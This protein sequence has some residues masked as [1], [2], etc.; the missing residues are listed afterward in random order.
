MFYGIDKQQQQTMQAAIESINSVYQQ[1][2]HADH[3]ITVGRNMGFLRDPHF[4][5]AMENHATNEQESS[6]A[7]RLHTLMWAAEHCLHL[8]GEFVECGVY[9]GFSTAVLAEYLDFSKVEKTFFLYDTFDGMPKESSRLIG[10]GYREYA[11]PGLYEFVQKRFAGYPN[12]QLVRG[13]IPQSFEIACPEKIA[14]LHIDLNCA[15]AELA[16]LNTLF[17]RVVPGGMI[18]L[19]DFGW[20]TYREQ[21]NVETA[22]MHERGYRILEV[23][24]G[25][26]LVV[27]R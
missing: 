3:L 22:F 21:H 8:P 4:L 7:W 23:P 25:Q 15:R 1:A 11:D 5:G 6:L 24:T 27:K 26:G 17:D 20:E 14:Y 16:A 2:F 9:R 13:L 18:I 12:I 10:T 19:D